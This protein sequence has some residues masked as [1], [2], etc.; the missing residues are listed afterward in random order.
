VIAGKSFHA[1]ERPGTIA[2]VLFT[3]TSRKSNCD[4]DAGDGDGD[5]SQRWQEQLSQ[6]EQRVRYQQEA[7]CAIS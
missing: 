7:M 6:P 5:E 3:K 2:R 1:K 4:D